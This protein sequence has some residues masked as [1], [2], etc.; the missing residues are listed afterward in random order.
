MGKL[1]D[2][3]LM[4]FKAAGA[5]A[6]I[7]GRITVGIIGCVLAGVGIFLISPVDLW[8]AGVPVFLVGLLLMGR[9]IF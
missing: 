8:W 1:S 2:T 9:S 4:P 6:R 5:F 7:S 3:F